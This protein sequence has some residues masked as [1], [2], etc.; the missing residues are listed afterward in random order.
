MARRPRPRPGGRL[1]AGMPATASTPTLWDDVDDPTWSVPELAEAI[2]RHLAGAF[3]DEVWVRGVVRNLARGR[4]GGTVWFDL[5]EPA[6]DGDLSRPARATLPVVLFDTARRRVNA[7]L[8][9]AGGRV[10][11][12]DGTEVRIRGRLSWYE[13]RGRL[14]L[15]M[16]D[17]D[18]AFTLGRLAADRD[19]LLRLLAGEGLLSRQAE[20]AR[21]L[22]PLRLGLV[23]SGGSAAE[24]DVLGELRSSGIG[25]S[26]VRADVRVQGAHAP[27]SVAAG[28][29][30]VAARGVDLVLL[31][32]GGG[33]T[34]DL[35][36]FDGE[37][38]AR[39]VAGL[40]VPVLTGIG[41]EVDRSV[42]DE[43]AHASYKTPTACAQ[44]V[45]ADV[46]AVEARTLALWRDIAAV[47]RRRTQA[48]ARHLH[49]CGRLVARATRRGLDAADRDLEARQ[50][51][52]G[53]V[54]DAALARSTAH[55]DRAVG[56]VEAGG[57]AHLRTHA[58]VVGSATARLTHR[59]PRLLAGAARHLDAV[60]AQVGALDPQRVL[61]RGW[62][63]TRTAGGRTVRSVAGLEPGHRI[64]TTLADG[65]VS[66][67]V[68][69]AGPAAGSPPGAAVPGGG[70]SG[71]V[72]GGPA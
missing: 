63:I 64:V 46:R 24:H 10:R 57:R 9:D 62:S 37:V 4:G 35:G 32:R 31:V 51:R 11:M 29:A 19:H 25:F 16:S 15:A 27:R 52:V 26:V 21:P 58:Q 12:T 5:V 23:T 8:T 43:V 1:V 45:V 36:A 40:A 69:A 2:A 34:T 33:A 41:H 50:A 56:R 53:R 3:P 54:A 14:Q 38:V 42:A 22:L 7:R 71:D 17:I 13:R 28:L 60:E 59:A 39:A 66:S 6:A 65:V 30:A 18:P 44:A 68:D 48:E 47:A 61:G 67:T 20:L 55:L 70:R 49:T 72:P